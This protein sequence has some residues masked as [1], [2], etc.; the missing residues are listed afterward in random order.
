MTK[1]SKTFGYPTHTYPGIQMLHV[2]EYL[3]C[4]KQNR[5][6]R[7]VGIPAYP[8]DTQATRRQFSTRKIPLPK[9]TFD[10]PERDLILLG[11]KS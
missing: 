6:L 7:S 1:I 3:T 9:S 10:M 8:L 5:P 4:P 11:R 2:S